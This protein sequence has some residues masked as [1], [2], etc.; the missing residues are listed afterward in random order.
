[1]PHD[2]TIIVPQ[3]NPMPLRVTDRTIVD[4][5]PR[6]S[7]EEIRQL[8]EAWRAQ[9]RTEL[10]A[11]VVQLRSDLATALTDLEILRDASI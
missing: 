3:R 6:A 11:L 5:S 8:S 1:M 10:H 7:L 9:R 2:G 4:D